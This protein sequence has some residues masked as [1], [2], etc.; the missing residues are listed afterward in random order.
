[1]SEK[2]KYSFDED[3]IADLRVSEKLSS[4]KDG[5]VLGMVNKGPAP[6]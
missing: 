6:C 3:N 5:K 2:F 4:V 1:M